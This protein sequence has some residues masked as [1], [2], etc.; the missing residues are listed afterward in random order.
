MTQDHN[1]VSS[2]LGH[3]IRSQVDRRAF[4]VRV[5]QSRTKR[6]DANAFIPDVVVIP[7]SIMTSHGPNA[8][9]EAYDEPLPFVAEVWSRSTGNYDVDE[10]LPEYRRR[11]DLEIWRVHP[12]ER[13]V[14]AWRR[15]ADGSYAESIYDQGSIPIESLPG[16]AVVLSELFEDVT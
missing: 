4:Q 13:Q 16:V 10:K 14:I 5:N 8:G 6:T 12:Y 7:R 3:I 2:W 11:G 15:Q 1:T 9:I